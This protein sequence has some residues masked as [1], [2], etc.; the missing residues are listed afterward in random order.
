[1][2][3][4]QDLRY[5]ARM[6]RANPGFTLV[7]VLTLALGIGANTAIFSF[8]DGVL[9]KPLPYAHPER[10]LMVWEKPPQGERNG[11]STLN[12]LD[13]R[14]QNTVFDRMAA[15]RGESVTMSGATEPVELRA[16]MVSAPFFEIF[17]V[18]AALGRT[19][20]NNEDTAGAPRVA[21]MSHRLWQNRFGADKSILG[22]KLILNGQPYTVVGVLPRNSA[23]DR[24]F[25]EIWLPLVFEPK[26]MTRNFHW[27]RSYARLKEGV[28]LEK[29][30]A[31]M[32]VVGAR[33]EKQYPDSNKGWSVTVDRFADRLVGNQLRQSLYVLLAAVGAVLLIGCANLANLTLAK[34]T[35]REREVAI[36]AS[37]GAGRWRLMRQFLTENVLLSLLGGCAGLALGWAMVRGLKFLMPPFMLPSEAEVSV[38]FRVL[39]FTLG[40]AVVTGVVFGLAPALQA[41]H[42]NLASTMKEGGRG[43]TASAARRRLRGGLVVLET[44]LAFVLLTGAGL[45]IRS[46]DRLQ[47][48][49]AGFDTTNVL[50]MHIP[51]PATRFKEGD[52]ATAHVQHVIQAIESVPGIREVAATSVLPLEGWSNGMPFQI[53]GKPIKDHANRE[54]CFFKQVTS[55]YFHALGIQLRK[56]RGL[57]ERDTKGGPPV[58]VINA[59]MAKKYFKDEDPIG[60]RIL[61]QEILYDRPGL[62]PEIAWQVVGVITD[63]KIGGLDDDRSAGMYI[64]FAQSPVPYVSLVV[65]GD[66]NPETMQQA[67]R[68]EVRQVDPDQALT[69]VKTLETIKSESVGANRMR[70]TLLGVF[71][72]I[73]LLL[74]AIGI[75]GVISYSVAQ[76]THEMGVRSALGA[77]RIDILRLVISNGML[78]AGIGLGIGLAGAFGLTRLLQSLLFGV[79]ATDPVTIVAVATVLAA[80]AL[81]ACYIPARRAT[82]VDPAVALRYE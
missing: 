45:L 36:R 72:G 71:A 26:D 31:E 64:P 27:F 63:E 80:V 25:F 58:A 18:Q 34:G 12:Y 44:G 40:I 68:H 1:M 4:A 82:K 23:Y 30:R 69:E 78:L 9:L 22:R 51:F 5:A 59:T 41:A 49:N 48:V 61:V 75:Y 56:G 35:S 17:G 15:Q 70:T 79:S 29:A 11:I 7:A 81:S 42:P 21:V 2:N 10:I 52:Q 20:A 37:L 67:I 16:G 54:A 39:L 24:S 8:V 19:F 76:R 53:A 60:Q 73:A 50:T 62:G 32:K 38:D 77:S 3:F 55:S 43:S 33:I 28:T 57:T 65:K 47:Q 74:A 6:L 13:W 66:V 14:A 46:F